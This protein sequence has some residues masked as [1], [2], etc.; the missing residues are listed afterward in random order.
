VSP[1]RSDDFRILSRTQTYG[2]G[3][4]SLEARAG[5]NDKSS[6]YRQKEIPVIRAS[7]C[8]DLCR[9]NAH[10]GTDAGSER[11]YASHRIGRGRG[12]APY[13]AQRFAA[14]VPAYSSNPG[15]AATLY[16]DFN[17]HFEAQWGSHSN[18]TTPVFSM[19]EDTTTF[20]SNELAAIKE[21]WQRVAEDFAPFNINVT[22]V[23]PGDFFKVLVQ[24]VRRHIMRSRGASCNLRVI[25]PFIGQTT[26]SV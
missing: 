22:T 2:V 26:T 14:V 24:R 12:F 9:R 13:G 11:R 19:D 6:A 8:A 21:V 1:R 25:S 16:L 23:D 10:V 3:V 18:I 15:A 20:A 17:G 5:P 7:T 4:S